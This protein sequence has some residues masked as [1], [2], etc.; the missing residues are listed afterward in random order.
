MRSLG[1]IAGKDWDRL[2]PYWRK[3][4]SHRGDCTRRPSIIVQKKREHVYFNKHNL[5]VSNIPCHALQSVHPHRVFRQLVIPNGD[6]R[7]WRLT[8]SLIER[9]TWSADLSYDILI[10]MHCRLLQISNQAMHRFRMHQVQSHQKRG[11]QHLN[12]DH[13]GSGN[14]SGFESVKAQKKV[15][16]LIFCFF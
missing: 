11:H 3:Y 9:A 12:R 6:F 7:S 15:H 16:A 2:F 5:I 1:E 4:G 14:R 10:G 8:P 13:H